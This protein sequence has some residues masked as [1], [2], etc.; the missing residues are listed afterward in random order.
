MKRL[1]WIDGFAGLLVGVVVLLVS[2]WLSQCYG[3]PQGLLHIIGVG[4][5]VYGLNSL[6]LAWRNNRPEKRIL[7][8]AFSNLMWAAV[9]VFWTITYWDSAGFLGRG[10]LLAE[11]LF[12]GGLG[13]LEWRWR[14]LLQS[15]N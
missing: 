9:C 14:T 5:T 4:N 8:V 3:L 7:L 10:H 6:S 11:A 13:C 2:D 1:L 12:V 15:R